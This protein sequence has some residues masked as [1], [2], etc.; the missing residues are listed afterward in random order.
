MD[1]LLPINTRVRLRLD[2]EITGTIIEHSY[3]DN[4]LCFKPSI[5]PYKIRWD[6]EEAAKKVIGFLCYYPP[7]RY[8]EEIK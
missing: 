3:S 7:P 1:K 5:L 6:N 8:L 2:P 4:G